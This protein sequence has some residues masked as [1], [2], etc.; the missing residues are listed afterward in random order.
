MRVCH[1][2]CWD[3]LG[4]LVEAHVLVAWVWGGGPDSAFL[5]SSA[6]GSA[7]SKSDCSHDNLSIP[8]SPAVS[9]S[10]PTSLCL[11]PCLSVC[12]PICSSFLPQLKR[13]RGE[14]AGTRPILSCVS[15][16]PVRAP[17][18]Q[19]GFLSALSLL[20]RSPHLDQCCPS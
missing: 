15:P 9:L 16:P 19:Q 8:I 11:S 1:T 7:R 18:P 13:G 2:E 12:S 5:A 10:L 17:A 4:G 3:S 6:S 14:P 20:A